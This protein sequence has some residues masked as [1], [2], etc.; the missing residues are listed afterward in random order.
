[1]AG[2]GYVISPDFEGDVVEHIEIRKHQDFMP[3]FLLNPFDGLLRNFPLA[4]VESVVMASRTAAIDSNFFR[5]V[6]SL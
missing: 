3:D 1:M 5:A 4:A 2:Q 6:F